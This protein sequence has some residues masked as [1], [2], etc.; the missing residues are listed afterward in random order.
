MIEMATSKEQVGRV[1]ADW[2]R[3]T[4]GCGMVLI[5]KNEMAI[6]WKGFFPDAED[7]IEAVSVPLG[8][9]SIFSKTYETQ[10]PFFGSPT[11]DGAKTN[12]LFWKLLRCAPPYEVLVCPVVLAR[13]TVN[14]IY[15]HPD[16]DNFISDTNFRQAQLLASNASDAYM[17][18]IKKD[19]VAKSGSS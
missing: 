3:S 18:F 7:L 1:L 2:L 13:R 19:R 6:G 9:P 4:F 12:Q 17:R 11:E 10:R 15:A 14:L 16:G 8:K 5:V